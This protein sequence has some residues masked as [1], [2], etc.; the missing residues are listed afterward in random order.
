MLIPFVHSVPYRGWRLA[1]STT[2]VK[3]LTCTLVISLTSCAYLKD[4]TLDQCKTH[5][6]VETVLEDYLSR[7]YQSGAPVRMG[8]IPLAVSA[9]L[10]QRPFQY[11]G[12]GNTLAYQLHAHFLNRET[13]PIVEVLNREDWPGKKEEF[14]TGNFGALSQA[15]E[16]GYDL[17]LVGI[18]DHYN[19]FSEIT[20]STKLIEVESGVTIWYG[21]TTAHTMRRDYH[22][23]AD[24]LGIEDRNPSKTF[25]DDLEPHLTK[26]IANEILSVNRNL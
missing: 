11:R 7:R 21:K 2:C 24:Y 10:T 14:Y 1:L 4:R 25:A 12:L 3:L 23:G 20:A 22:R 19:P 18:V 26:C 8:I 17:I 15:R 16:A 9:N 13:V 5:A 6:Y